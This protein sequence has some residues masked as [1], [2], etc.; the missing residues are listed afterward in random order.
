MYF[1][2]V[3][4]VSD[5]TNKT[6]SVYYASLA[7]LL[8]LSPISYAHA[9]SQTPAPQNN[10]LSNTLSNALPQCWSAQDLAG[11]KGENRI[12]SRVPAAFRMPPE[13]TA[14]KPAIPSEQW[15][16]ALGKVIRRVDLPKGIK[17]IALTFDLC[18]QPH[19]ISGYQGTI[20]DFLREEDVKATFFSGGK[21]MLTHQG[22]AQQLMSDPLFE[23]A[24]HSWEHRNLRLLKGTQLNHSI[25]KAQLAFTEVRSKLKTKMCLDRT[26]RVKAVANA[27]AQMSL[28]RFPFGAC[29]KPALKAV[30]D[31]GLLSIQW[32][33]SAGDP[34]KGQSANRIKR[35]VLGK[36]KSGSIVIFHA[37]GRGWHTPKAL[38]EIVH[39][40]KKQGYSFVTVGELLQTK[41][42][43]WVT[44]QTCYD[45][46]PGDSKRYDKVARR[47]HAFYERAT[48]R[49]YAHF[50]RLPYTPKNKTFK[51][52]YRTKKRPQTR[53]IKAHKKAP[54]LP[55]SPFTN[56]SN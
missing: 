15:R 36:V 9:D 16:N 20:I 4:P 10:T 3:C 55:F 7:I 51:T 54:S 17:K 33:V 37:N 14:Q 38:P 34:V 29:N 49:H 21:W 42:A 11:K 52:R 43:R 35:A 32:D 5:C 50:A 48:A 30:G 25:E 23:M 1:L 27:P 46:H 45:H 18:E 2:S 41:G 47:L 6:K 26:G 12:K 40:L 44:K 39:A 19:E 24:N 13:G 53:I 56:L 8:A 22:R 28:F 31:A